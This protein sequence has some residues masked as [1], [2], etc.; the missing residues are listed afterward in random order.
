MLLHCLNVAKHTS[1]CHLFTIFE[2]LIKEVLKN[3]A[4]K[5]KVN[6]QS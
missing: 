2:H 6:F 3:K 1:P 5:Y 4:I